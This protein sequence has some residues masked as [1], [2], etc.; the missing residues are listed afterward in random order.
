MSNELEREL[1]LYEQFE[2]EQRSQETQN[3][4]ELKKH[5]SLAA[6]A[7]MTKKQN[8]KAYRAVAVDGEEVWSADVVRAVYCDATQEIDRL[9][10]AKSDE[11]FDLRL[12]LVRGSSISSSCP[13]N[14]SLGVRGLR[15]SGAGLYAEHYAEVESNYVFDLCPAKKGVQP[16]SAVYAAE[17]RR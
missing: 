12:N 14:F 17:V 1:L 2:R 7:A 8:I 13:V 5:Y 9:R 3:L 10:K 16:C 4:L 11:A 15:Y 6:W